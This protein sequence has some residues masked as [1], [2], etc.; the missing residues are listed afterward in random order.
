M[1][2]LTISI[3]QEMNDWVEAQ[4]K[5]GRYHNASEYFHDLVRHDQDRK[6]SIQELR[7]IMSRAEA[8][9]IFN[10]TLSDIVNAARS[11]AREKGLL[12]GQD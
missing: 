8:S 7:N 9:G 2:R 11:E 10:R 1:S 3:S 4:I 6:S 5:A 12:S